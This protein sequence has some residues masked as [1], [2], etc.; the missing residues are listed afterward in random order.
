MYSILPWV[1]FLYFQ[2]RPFLDLFHRLRCLFWTKCNLFPNQPT[3]QLVNQ[4]NSH[5]TFCCFNIFPLF[6]FLGKNIFDFDTK[7]LCLLRETG[8]VFHWHIILYLS[9]FLESKM[10]RN[11]KL[12]WTI[13]PFSEFEELFLFS[14]TSSTFSLGIGTTSFRWIT[15]RFWNILLSLRVGLMLLGT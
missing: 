12:E 2:R 15:L 13:F 6:Q 1:I 10:K 14:I 3:N 9:L 11:K 8:D 5:L 7:A 4:R